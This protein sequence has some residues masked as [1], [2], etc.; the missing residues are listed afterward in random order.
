MV[1]HTGQSAGFATYSLGIPSVSNADTDMTQV[2]SISQPRRSHQ[3]LLSA[4]RSTRYIRPGPLRRVIL[5]VTGS[6]DLRQTEAYPNIVAVEIA[7][8]V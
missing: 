2:K 7:M 4:T 1:G 3:D 8:K 6:I 5:H